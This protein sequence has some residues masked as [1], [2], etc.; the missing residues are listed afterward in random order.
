MTTTPGG[1]HGGP[2]SGDIHALSGAYAVDALDDAERAEFEHHLAGCEACRWEVDSLREASALLPEIAPISPPPALRDRVLAE[3]ATVRPLPPE[4]PAGSRAPEPADTVVPIRR[5]S[6]RLVTGLVA[7]AAA[8]ALVGGGVTVWQPW[9]DE[10][11]QEIVASPMQQV[12]EA[13]DAERYEQTFPDGAKATLVR[14]ESMNKAVL[15]TEDMP[16]PPEG[17]V[18]ELWLDHEEVGMVPAGLMEAGEHSLMLEGDPATALAAGITVEPA[19]GS[20]EPTSEPV[21]LF[22]FDEA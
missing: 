2:S 20:E 13:E 21:A 17:K 12:L 5:R 7:A 3:I 14:S 18:Y 1:R 22:P 9:D 16:P 6:R 15:L 4:V 8:V 19:G 10:P 11:G